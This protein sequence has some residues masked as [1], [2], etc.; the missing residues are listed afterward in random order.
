MR[1]WRNIAS[2]AT[3]H[4]FLIQRAVIFSPLFEKLGERIPPDVGLRDADHVSFSKRLVGVKDPDK[5]ASRRMR[6]LP[7]R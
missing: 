5:T 7:Q 3:S 2:L 1:S 4:V 6:T